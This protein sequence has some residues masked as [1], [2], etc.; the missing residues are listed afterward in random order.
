MFFKLKETSPPTHRIDTLVGANAK[1]DGDIAF[2]GGLRIDGAVKGNVA[3]SYEDGGV[4]CVGEQGSI[5]GDV[6]VND[7]ILDGAIEGTVFATGRVEIRSAGRIH[8][9]VHA[10]VIEIHGGAVV[11]GRIISSDKKAD[12]GGRLLQHNPS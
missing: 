5:V 8:G 12:Q 2:R 4:L 7:L 9:D 11:D 6:R 1:I 3:V 10:G